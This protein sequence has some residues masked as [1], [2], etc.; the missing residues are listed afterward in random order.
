MQGF[1]DSHGQFCTQVD[2]A[3]ARRLAPLLR[4]AMRSTA[5]RLWVDDMVYA[6]RSYALRARGESYG[7]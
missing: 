3:V 1:Q 2:F 7:I 4:P 6:E 5:R